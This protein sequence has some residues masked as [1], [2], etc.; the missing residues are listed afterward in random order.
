MAPAGHLDLLNVNTSALGLSFLVKFDCGNTG[1]KG[2]W[3]NSSE[4][5]KFLK[6]Q[7]GGLR[8]LGF[9]KC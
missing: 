1:H 3:E 5:P 4:M 2:N 7:D 6:I 9:S 8:H